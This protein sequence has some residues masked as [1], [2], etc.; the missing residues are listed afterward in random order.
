MFRLQRFAHFAKVSAE[1][2]LESFLGC[3][4]YSNSGFSYVWNFHEFDFLV[5]EANWIDRQK[6]TPR[7]GLGRGMKGSIPHYSTANPRDTW[8]HG[9]HG[10]I[11]IAA[12]KS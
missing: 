6:Y 7:E 2:N 10:S 4:P 5:I 9:P 8:A 11:H 12:M 3:F 1:V